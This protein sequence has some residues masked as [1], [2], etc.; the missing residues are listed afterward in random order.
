MIASRESPSKKCKRLE[1]KLVRKTQEA[2]IETDNDFIKRVTFTNLA[3]LKQ[4][5][6][7]Q[8]VDLYRTTIFKGDFFLSVMHLTDLPDVLCSVN[9]DKNLNVSVLYKKVELKK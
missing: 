4:C 9:V 7:S 5:L 8:G 1:D 6:I 2:S 3:E